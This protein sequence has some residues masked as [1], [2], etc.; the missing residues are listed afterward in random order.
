LL[1]VQ[2][3]CDGDC[4]TVDGLPSCVPGNLACTA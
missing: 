4:A 2:R 1:A 3:A